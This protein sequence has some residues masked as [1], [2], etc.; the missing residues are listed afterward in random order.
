[1]PCL[2]L[3]YYVRI[4]EEITVVCSSSYRR[5]NVDMDWA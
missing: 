2:W 1:M 5:E 4:V 3:V